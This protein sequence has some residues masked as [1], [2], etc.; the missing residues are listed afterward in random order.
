[1]RRYKL[2][3]SHRTLLTLA[4]DQRRVSVGAQRGHALLWRTSQDSVQTFTFIQSQHPQAADLYYR[5]FLP[6]EDG[7]EGVREELLRM[8]SVVLCLQHCLFSKRDG[9]N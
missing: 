9:E 5:L 2:A 4:V 3:T 8:M 6:S 7:T 1:M